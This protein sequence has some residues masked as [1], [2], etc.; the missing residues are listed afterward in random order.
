M[1]DENKQGLVLASFFYGY[2]V[3]QA[4]AMSSVKKLPL[5]LTLRLQDIS[6]RLGD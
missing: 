6:L 3:T 5:L 4:R 2:V 1:W